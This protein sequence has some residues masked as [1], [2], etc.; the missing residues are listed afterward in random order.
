MRARK[1]TCFAG[2]VA[3]LLGVH[4]AFASGES[5]AVVTWDLLAKV[6]FTKQRDRYV[7]EF[8]KEIAALEK[9]DVRLQG[10][11]M[12]LDTGAMQRR[13]LLSALPSECGFC[14]PA[15]AEQIVE[16]QAKQGVKYVLDAVTVSGKFT[17]VRDDAG[18]LLYRLTEAVA[19]QK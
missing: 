6:S 8:A 2:V 19:I 13:F 10:F 9:K 17:L 7:P 3:L 12:P 16:V 4:C 14:M 11:M 15:G 18:G 1:A 5:A